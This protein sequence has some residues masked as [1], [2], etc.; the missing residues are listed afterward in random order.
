MKKLKTNVLINEDCI[1]AM[2]AMPDESIDMIF[3]DPPY[4]LQLGEGLTRPNNSVVNGV[5]DEWDKFDDFKQYDDFSEAWMKEAHRILKPNGSF[6]VIGSYHNI[7]RVGAKLQDLG[8]W[9]LNDVIW[10]K[11]NPMPNFRGTRFTNAH[12]TMIWSSKSKDAKYT[13]NYHALKALNEDLQMRSDWYMSLCTGAER[14][15]DKN[16]DKI[17]P[18][19]KPESLLYRV[20]IASTNPGDVVLDPFSGTGTTAAVAKKLGRQYIGIEQDKKYLKEAEK[21]LKEITPGT[22]KELEITLEKRKEVRIPFGNLIEKGL[23]SAGQKLISPCKKF[24][25]NVRADGS[26]TSEKFSGSIHK[27]GAMVQ[28]AP[29]CNGWTYW[30]LPKN[31]EPIDELRKLLRAEI[32]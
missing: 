15:K 11:N 13:F 10:V 28:R 9:V 16:G 17:H 3:A 20:M 21:R 1:K 8:F 29:S 24:T 27:V 5:N 14:L 4:N 26:I 22:E 25:A 23:I 31:A 18:T 30:R 12:E 19:Q 7:F 2:K 6:W 32:G